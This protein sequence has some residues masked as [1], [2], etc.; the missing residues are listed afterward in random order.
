MQNFRF[1]KFRFEDIEKSESWLAMK[2]TLLWGKR[3]K[4]KL[5]K[6][7]FVT[8]YDDSKQNLMQFSS[9]RT[10]RIHQR[11]DQLNSSFVAPNKIISLR[12]W[13][14]LRRKKRIKNTTNRFWSNWICTDL[15]NQSEYL[16]WS[17]LGI[18]FE[19]LMTLRPR[20]SL[21]SSSKVVSSHIKTLVLEYEGI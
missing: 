14:Y 19:F 5:L 17:W 2:H 4:Q 8:W 13:T 6:A 3:K 10:I 21:A 16:H 20:L 7:R 11:R 1:R 15:D 18:N 9:D 12:F